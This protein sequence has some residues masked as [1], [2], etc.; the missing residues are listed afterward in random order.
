MAILFGFKA[1]S[2]MIEPKIGEEFEVGGV[3][4]IRIQPVTGLELYNTLSKCI[5]ALRLSDYQVV[6]MPPTEPDS[7]DVLACEE[8]KFSGGYYCKMCGKYVSRSVIPED[9]LCDCC[10]ARSEML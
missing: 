5:F 2:N 8:P 4:Y 7:V 6:I 10:Y 1:V 9:R 3:S